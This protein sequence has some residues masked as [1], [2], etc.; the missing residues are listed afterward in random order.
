GAGAS[1]CCAGPSVATGS[2]RQP[3]AAA[4]VPGGARSRA[5][6]VVGRAPASRAGGG[7]RRT[8]GRPMPELPA[9]PVVLFEDNH[10]L[11]VAKPAPLLTQGVPVGIPT[12]EA[13]VK[14]Y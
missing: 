9:V 7:R 3:G 1:A 14:A 2:Y 4:P 11:A 10:C 13:Q 12:L 8:W 6:G 5:R